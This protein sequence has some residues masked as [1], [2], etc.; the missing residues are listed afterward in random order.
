MAA[1]R[2]RSKPAGDTVARELADIKRL[3]VLAL[4]R[5]GASQAEVANALGVSQPSISRMSPPGTGK[6]AKAPRGRG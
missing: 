6:A 2:K 1:K 5:S 3:L 4:R